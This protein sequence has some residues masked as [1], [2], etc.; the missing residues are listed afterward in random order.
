GQVNYNNLVYVP[1]SK[2]YLHDDLAYVV[3]D[4]GAYASHVTEGA[5]A[6]FVPADKSP[7]ITRNEAQIGSYARLFDGAVLW[8]PASPRWSAVL[9]WVRGKGPSVDQL[10]YATLL[11]FAVAIIG[12]PFAVWRRRDDPAA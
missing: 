1:I 10:S 11:A 12:T 9:D 4:P 2:R 5:A 8:Q 3:T 7:L 6:W